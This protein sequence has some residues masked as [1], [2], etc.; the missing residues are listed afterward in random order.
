MVYFRG[1]KDINKKRGNHTG[2]LM[3]KLQHNINVCLLGKLI[4][5]KT[6]D[7]HNGN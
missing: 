1:F 6:I 4:A 2:N 3:N 5:V 7:W